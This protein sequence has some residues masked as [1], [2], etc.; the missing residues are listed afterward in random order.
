MIISWK[1]TFAALGVAMVLGAAPG[2]V[3]RMDTRYAERWPDHPR[4]DKGRQPLFRPDDT[5]RAEWCNLHVEFD[6][7]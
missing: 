5:R 3:G 6:L 4:R 1:R 2:Q 7:P